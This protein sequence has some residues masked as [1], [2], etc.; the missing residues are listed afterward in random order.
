MKKKT[1]ALGKLENRDPSKTRRMPTDQARCQS[2]ARVPQRR[3]WLP[4][5]GTGNSQNLLRDQ[6]ATRFTC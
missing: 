6:A 5:T 2:Q 1:E 3:L 4:G